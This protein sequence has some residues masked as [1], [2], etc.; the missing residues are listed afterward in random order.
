MGINDVW[1]VCPE[2]NANSNDASATSACADEKRVK[3]VRADP[4]ACDPTRGFH[5]RE[6]G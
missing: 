2:R 6:A 1:R 4:R 5:D 3:P